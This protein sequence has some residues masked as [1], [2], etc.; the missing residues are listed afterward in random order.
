VRAFW[1]EYPKLNIDFGQVCFKRDIIT[2][3]GESSDCR[4]DVYVFLY[5]WAVNTKAVPTAISRW[6][7][8]VAMG[9]ENIEGEHVEDV[10]AWQQRSKVQPPSVDADSKGAN[11]VKKAVTPFPVHELTRGVPTEGWVCFVIRGTKA[12]WIENGTIQLTATDSFGHE[13][14]ISRLGPWNCS[15]A[16]VKASVA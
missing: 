12:S 13:H 16:M 1:P 9:R 4:F 2:L 10:S 8:S 15:G 11:N 7:F 6:K 3:D 5:V 14:T